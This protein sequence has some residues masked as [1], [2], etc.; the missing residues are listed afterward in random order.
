MKHQHFHVTVSLKAVSE[1][2]VS[3]KAIKKMLDAALY[4]LVTD[5]NDLTEATIHDVIDC[6]VRSALRKEREG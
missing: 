4:D 1:K 5:P 6:P 2:G 3:E